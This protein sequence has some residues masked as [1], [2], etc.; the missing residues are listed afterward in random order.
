MLPITHGVDYTRRQILLYTLILVIA[1][2]LPF[3]TYMSGVVYLCGAILLDAG[4]LYYAIR[5]QT[6]HDDAL[7]MR[8]FKYSIV[9]LMGIFIFFFLD[10]YWTAVLKLIG[11]A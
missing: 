4:F 9:Y 3:V 10:H 2:L 1:T 6:D 11:I 7:A 5:M 8:T